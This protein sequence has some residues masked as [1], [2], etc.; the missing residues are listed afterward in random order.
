ISCVRGPA[1]ADRLR[2]TLRGLPVRGVDYPEPANQRTRPCRR[3]GRHGALLRHRTALRDHTASSPATA[4]LTTSRAETRHRWRM[5][6]QDRARVL[7]RGQLEALTD[8][9]RL[10]RARVVFQAAVPTFGRV[11]SEQQRDLLAADT[12]DHA[13][14]SAGHGSRLP[15]RA[16]PEVR[17]NIAVCR[18]QASWVC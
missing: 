13:E 6:A 11:Q 14:D 7:S 2:R 3:R 8:W 18:M 12:L 1:P 17:V 10:A 5:R 15:L 4:Q 9:Q 16:A